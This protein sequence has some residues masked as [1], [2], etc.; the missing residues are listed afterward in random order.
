MLTK[1]EI[2]SWQLPPA[3]A[4]LR[5]TVLG[6][7]RTGEA[8]SRLLHQ[9]GC[10]VL[11]SDSSLSQELEVK[12]AELR[13]LGIGVEI[14]CHT[15]NALDC[16]LIVRSPGVPAENTI[17]QE[18]YQRSIMVVSEIEVAA[19]FCAAPIVA[20]TGSNGKTTTVEWIGDALRRSGL[21]AVVC[22]NVGYPF[23]RAIMEQEQMDVAVVEVSSFQLEDVVRFSPRI[24]VITNLSPDHLD[25]YASYS[26]YVSVKYRIFE[27]L[28]AGSGLVY[29]RGDSELSKG[30]QS[31]SGRKLSFGLDVPVNAGAGLTRDGM[32]YWDG[33]SLQNLIEQSELALPGAHNLENALAMICTAADLGAAKAAICESLR[34]FPGVP[35]R[36]EEVLEANGVLW[37]E[38]SKATNIASGLVALKSFSQP[39]ILLA[40]GRDKGGDFKAI[41]NQVERSVKLA[42]LF[43]EAG[44]RI[45]RAWA[46]VVPSRRV[47]TLEE[48]VQL[49]KSRAQRGEVVLLSPMCASFDQFKNYEERGERFKAIVRE[50]VC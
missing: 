12:A 22:G 1:D 5:I 49:A 50:H 37:V 8:V 47:E 41:A 21:N 29:N 23:S 39:I 40:G 13:A 38:D 24:A 32:V 3:L 9:Q 6:L 15:A 18:A 10:C 33:A 7:A 4:G 26:D 35:H 2:H 42:I 25:R 11:V 27:N 17:L 14:G 45:Q 43:G 28:Y 48:A 46:G 19:W 34:H 31:A 16:D 30:V 36:L 44:E 20:V